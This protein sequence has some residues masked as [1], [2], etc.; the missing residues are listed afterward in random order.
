MQLLELLGVVVTSVEAGGAFNALVS[1]TVTSRFKFIYDDHLYRIV[2]V[3][4]IIIST[5]KHPL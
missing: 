5:F 3:S 4:I 1:K 2:S